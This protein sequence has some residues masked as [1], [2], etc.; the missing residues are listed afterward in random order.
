MA[1]VCGKDNGP[2]FGNGELAAEEPF[3]GDNK[4]YSY[5]NRGGYNIGKDRESRSMLTNLK[6]EWQFIGYESRFTI[7]ELEVWEVIFEK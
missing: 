5:A 3:N 1:I 6:C 2:Y 7:S 4:C